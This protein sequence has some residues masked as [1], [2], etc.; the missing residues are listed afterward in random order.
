MA[1]RRR[2]AARLLG[3]RPAETGRAKAVV[4]M[5]ALGVVA[6]LGVARVGAASTF[7]VDRSSEPAQT[8]A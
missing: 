4:A 3:R 8:Q 1:Q 5:A 2:S 7:E 6:A